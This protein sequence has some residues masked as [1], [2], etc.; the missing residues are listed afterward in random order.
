MT[1]RVDVVRQ[2][3][4]LGAEVRGADLSKPL[5]DETFDAIHR[6]FV[7]HQVIFF[8]EQ[9]ITPQQEL[10]FASRFGEPHDYP[11]AEG[12]PECP[13]VMPVIKEPHESINFGNQWHSDT[14]YLLEPPLATVLY[15]KEMP[16]RGGDT[17]FSNMYLAY[18]GLSEGMKALLGTMSAVNSA[19][20]LSFERDRYASVKVKNA[21]R[22][23]QTEA[24]H[25]VVRVHPDTG[26]KALYVNETHTSHFQDMTREESLPLLGY[27]FRHLT[28]PEFTFRLR[29]ERGTIT[30]WDNR[31]TQHFAINDYHGQR[32]VMHR[33][34]V[35]GGRPVGE[36]DPRNAPVARREAA[37][38]G[39]RA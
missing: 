29:W 20:V 10:A 18:E 36:R 9:T 39:A 35:G 11:F 5:D 26:R 23:Q 14:A 33:V 19:T 28:K 30:V 27:L 32:R 37:L 31:C 22:Q 13:K 1:S 15:C 16:A 7:D 24:A 21:E 4:A 6:A 3:N 25:P 17:L 12:L 8:R 2:S 38:S 34:T